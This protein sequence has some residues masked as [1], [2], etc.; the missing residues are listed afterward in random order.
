MNPTHQDIDILK[1]KLMDLPTFYAGKS[2]VLELKAAN[3]NWRQMEWL[4]FYFEFKVKKRLKDVFQ[5]PG[6]QFNQVEFDLR[7]GFNWDIKTKARQS[8]S[9]GVILNDVTAMDRSVEMH[10][11][12]GEIIGVFDVEYNDND[13]SFKRWHDALKG[14]PSSYVKKQMGR[15]GVR[16]RQRKTSAVLREI[17]YILLGNDSLPR[18]DKMPQGK[19]SNG[20]PR[21]PKYMLNL[22][23]VD[24]F[25]HERQPF[26][27]L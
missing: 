5:I 20:M 2:S 24:E 17:Y 27:A 19:N 6:D 18:L 22:E 13:R 11:Y 16:S 26:S 7:T 15:P 25:K 8:R 12:H 21:P 14:S 1:S 3:Y 10:G 9:K 23:K 4:G